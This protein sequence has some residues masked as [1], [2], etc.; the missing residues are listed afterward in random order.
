MGMA[1]AELTKSKKLGVVGAY[2]IPELISTIN[3]FTLGARS[4]DPRLPLTSFG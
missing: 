2:A 3:G 1:A 4:T